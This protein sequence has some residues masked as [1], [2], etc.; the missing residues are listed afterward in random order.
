MADGSDAN[1]HVNQKLGF[2]YKGTMK[3]VGFK[4]GRYID[5]HLYQLMLESSEN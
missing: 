3:E 5:V 1:I 2:E 4:C